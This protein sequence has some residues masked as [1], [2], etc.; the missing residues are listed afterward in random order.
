MCPRAVGILQQPHVEVAVGPSPRRMEWAEVGVET[1][2]A[3]LG[4][5][6]GNAGKWFCSSPGVAKQGCPGADP[7]RAG[8][9]TLTASCITRAMQ[10]SNTSE[11]SFLL[12]SHKREFSF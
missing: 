3:P 7:G 12:L 11:A 4:S 1:C 8:K 6:E 9:R 2:L 10:W 5:E